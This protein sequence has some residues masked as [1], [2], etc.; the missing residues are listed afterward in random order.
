LI[1][2]VKRHRS[3]TH[4]ELVVAEDRVFE[5]SDHDVDRTSFHH[6]GQ[7]LGEARVGLHGAHDGAEVH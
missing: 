1:C 5:R 2:P 6:P 3:H 7:M 4:V